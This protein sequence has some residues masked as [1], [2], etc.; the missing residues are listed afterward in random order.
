M[1]KQFI[2]INKDRLEQFLWKQK[3]E[4]NLSREKMAE[5]IGKAKDYFSTVIARGTMDRTSLAFLCTLYEIDQEWL[6]TEDEV[7]VKN[8]QVDLTGIETMLNELNARVKDV[9]SR[10]SVI[11]EIYQKLP[12]EAV[13]PLTK[14]ERASLLL[15]Q[16][17]RY[18]SCQEK[19][20]RARCH[21][22]GIPEN[23]IKR[24]I[25]LEKVTRRMINGC[26]WL[27]R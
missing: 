3:K 16:F 18:G 4:K 7:A 15:K 11:E 21:D 25:D 19:L 24:A 12:L 23:E 8:V 9:Q 10:M 6:T 14:T 27:E 20:Y 2:K 22:D 5:S 26:S 17:L 1:A 13:R